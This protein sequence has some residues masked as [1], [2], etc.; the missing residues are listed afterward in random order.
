MKKIFEKLKSYTLIFYW[1]IVFLATTML[2]YL[3]LPGEV[4]F[5]YEYQ[6]GFPWKHETLVA[7]FDFAILKSEREL[8]DEKAEQAKIVVPYFNY[9]TA[10]VSGKIR[11]LETDLGIP[12]AYD[13]PAKTDV[14]NQLK[15][16]LTEIYSRGILQRSPDM[17]PEMEGK[18]EIW[19]KTGT[20]VTKSAVELIYSEKTAYHVL[21][22][23]LASMKRKH[24]ELQ[25][26]LAGISAEN[27][28][29]SNLQFDE[30]TTRKALDEAM[31]NISAT[32]GM[33]RMGDRVILQGEMVN[34][35]KFQVLESLKE[36]Y[37]KSGGAGISR[38]IVSGGKIIL[39]LFLS[40]LVFTFLYSY[41]R[42][43]L[44]QFPKL[45][46]LMMFMVAMVFITGLIGSIPNLNIYLVPLAIF[47]IVVRTFFDSRTATFLLI[48]ITLLLGF[49][50]PNSYE[51]ILLQFTAG[52]VA[53]FS[54]N[55]MH[56][57]KHLVIASIWVF[58]TYTVVF[59]A[60]NFIHEGSFLS[61]D[62]AM[63][64]WFALSSLLILLVYPLIF[65]FEKLFGFVSDVTLIELSDTNQPLLRK[66]AEEAPGTFQHSMQ[67]ANL[68]EEVILRIGGNPFL[69]RAGA[70]YHDIGKVV[71]PNF[72]I[73]NQE[74]GMNPHDNMNYFKS[75]EV[76]IDHVKNGVK[77]A[78]KHKL[79]ESLIEFIATHHGTTK[80]KYFFL[81]HQQ[82]NPG[83]VIDE[84]SFAYP[85]P[86]PKSKEASVVMLI[87]GIE[88]ASRSLKEKTMESLRELI[89]TMID[90]KMN[91]KQLDQSN[92]TFS[93][94]KIIKEILLKKL[95]NIYHIRIEYPKEEK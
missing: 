66:L 64:K 15:A 79:P 13:N 30:I 52:V 92:L 61:Y 26:W 49:Y 42:D 35:E 23:T 83:E 8:E 27:Y 45:L 75:A 94:I 4:K 18:A 48:I 32:R 67:I 93:D 22:E 25:K 59:S 55:K 16:S 20:L 85:G 5:R 37:E 40:G 81:K 88:A 78:K 1:I 74:M 70:L 7:P 21:N 28:I 29:S 53:V 19:K 82:E 54:L 44:Y 9:D 46:F 72:F 60:L 38:F 80:A 41:R 14:I 33:V 86:L 36:S 91:D 73:E 10:I 77:M 34:S 17:Y 90:Q 87:D 71:K 3:I 76:I 69:V 24:P 68:A 31:R 89:T 2:L 47:P 39:I 57:R 12:A 84:N 58:L 6:K 65:I 63:L 51:F 56:R 95:V 43:T 62:Y 50:A 11:R